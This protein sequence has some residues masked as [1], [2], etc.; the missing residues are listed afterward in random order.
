MGEFEEAI[1]SLADLAGE[2]IVDFRDEHHRWHLYQ[3]VINSERPDLRDVLYQVIGR[4]EDD[5][6]ALTVVL[7]VLEQVPEVERHAW[8]DRLRTSKSH[9]YASAR[10]FDIGMLESILQGAIS[11]NAWQALQERSDWLQLRLARRSESAVVLDELANSG[12]TKRIRR[13]AAERLAKLDS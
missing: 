3:R 10:S 1:R 5:A 4:D 9:Q 13:L 2:E 12:R 8:V 11:E 7:H 6:L